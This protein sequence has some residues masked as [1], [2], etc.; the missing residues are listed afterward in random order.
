M[1]GASVGSMKILMLSNYFYPEKGASPYL[2]ENRRQAFA[3]AGFDMELYTPVPT[4]GISDEVR[5][6]Y[7]HRLYEEMLDGKLKVHRFPLMRETKN[8]LQR[9]FRYTVSIIKLYLRARKTKDVDVLQIGSTPPINGLMF[10]SLKKKLNCKIVYNLQDIFPDSLLHAGMTKRGSLLWKL[11]RRIEDLTYRY[12]DVIVVLS[13]DFRRNI[14]E[15]GVPEDKIVMIRNWVDEQAVVAIDRQDNPLFDT[16]GLDRSRFYVC[17]SGNVG[18]SQNMDMLLDVA[19]S[20][21]DNEH[22]GFVIVGD[23]AYKK[24]VEQRVEQEQITNVTLIP[25]QP[26]KQIGQVFSLGDCG[27]II[28]KA[29]TGQNS[30][31]SKTW[32]VMSAARPVLACFDKDSELDHIVTDHD[33]GICVP[34]DD[35][36]AFRQA[37]LQMAGDKEACRRQGANGR[38]YIEDNLTRAVGTAKWVEVI[39]RVTEGDA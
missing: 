24:Q 26:Y 16:Y 12:A 21:R 35:A 4:R 5:K 18:M 25:F 31:P 6:E 28:S 19:K 39:R 15:K 9:A 14:I 22:I 32:S 36:E 11:G 38:Q 23:G 17:Y 30:V 34:P 2:G 10:P 8:P 37:I 1:L 3:D 13:E 7:S 33:C 29:G 27:L 20:L